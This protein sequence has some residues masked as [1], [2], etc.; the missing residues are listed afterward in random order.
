M[1][2]IL[3][4]GFEPFGSHSINPSALAAEQLD[5]RTIAGYRV[6]TQLL[7][8][9]HAAAPAAL[10]AALDRHRPT[11]TLSLGLAGGRQGLTVERVAINSLDFPLPDNAGAQV[12]D[13]PVLVGGPAAYFSSLPV[14]A[15]AT[16]WR[17]TGI[18]GAVSNSAGTYICNQV[19]YHALHHLQDAGTRAGFI[20][21]PYLPEQV[22]TERVAAG[23][24]SLDL[25][26]RGIEIALEAAISDLCLA[27]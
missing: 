24:M 6:R 10:L 4:T 7:P 5:G 12:E 3:I 23:S 14:R 8:V 20:H 22:V 27:V 16:R 2:T 25:M 1:S 11:L 17:A 15:I 26:I 21:L 13:E 19:L 18:P 9:D